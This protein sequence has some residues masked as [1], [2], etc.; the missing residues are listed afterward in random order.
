MDGATIRQQADKCLEQ[1]RLL[2]KIEDEVYTFDKDC[3]GQDGYEATPTQEQLAR[4]EMWA[5]N[6]G[7]FADGHASL[8]YRVRNSED[9]RRF[10]V[11]FLNTLMLALRKGM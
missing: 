1:F 7:V 3:L 11:E 9:A 4:F 8:D 5:G 6:I 2:V 10:M